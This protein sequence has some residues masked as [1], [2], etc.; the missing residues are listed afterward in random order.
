MAD[1]ITQASPRR[2]CW[3]LSGGLV[4]TL[5]VQWLTLLW[6]ADYEKQAIVQTYRERLQA[7]VGITRERASALLAA[8]GSRL[9]LLEQHINQRPGTNPLADREFT[10][11][12]QELPSIDGINFRLRLVDRQG[13]MRSGHP[14]ETINLSQH[15]LLVAQQQQAIR[16][17]LIAPVDHSQLAGLPVLPLSWPIRQPRN[18][19]IAAVALV[20]LDALL[21]L[22]EP[23]R[24][25][26]H[27]NMAI[28]HQDG[29]LLARLPYVRD[30]IGKSVRNNPNFTQ[31]LS[32]TRSGF[33]R[34]N[35]PSTDQV[36]RLIAFEHLP[37]HPLIVLAGAGEQEALQVWAQKRQMV[38]LLG[39]GFSLLLAGLYISLLLAINRMQQATWQ[40]AQLATTDPLT[41][42]MNRRAFDQQAEREFM[43]AQRYHTPLAVMMLDIDHFKRVNDTHGHAIGDITLRQLSTAWHSTLR[44]LDSVG[45]LGG[46]E[47]AILLPQTTLNDARMLG[48]RLRL[49]TASL[50]IPSASGPFRVTVSIGISVA[51]TYDSEF[52]QILQRAD[53]ALYRA[54]QLGRDQ[55]QND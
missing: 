30:Y 37:D 35:S 11:Q 40:L 3:L 7:Q 47:F 17:L 27:G 55:V 50:D 26:P 38:F 34:T 20:E 45:R 13:Q 12:L 5:L 54:K 8:A 6:W 32:R 14:G 2:Y 4:L 51:N 44:K 25:Q 46:E 19:W 29:T 10:R 15:P 31:I 39:A 52:S 18:R 28:M 23:L 43:R 9:Q 53:M 49:L 16:Q 36:A 48:E 24:I 1:T 42:R 41:G 21:K 33:Y 22:L